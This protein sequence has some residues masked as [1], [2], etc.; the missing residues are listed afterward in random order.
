[1]LYHHRTLGDGAEGVHIREMVHALRALG[2]DVRVSGVAGE[3]QDS[4]AASRS[5]WAAAGN[6]LPGAMYEMAEIG[7]NAL[8]RAALS[9]A[10]R[11]F[12]PHVIYDRY[13]TY[14][15]AAVA[16]GRAYRIPVMLEVNAVAHER[17][18]YERHRLRMAP[19]ARAYERWICTA[20]DHVF[21]VSTPLARVLAAECGVDR[22]RLTVLPNG[23]NPATF[24]PELSGAPVRQR[25]GLGNR[26]VLGFVG[27]LRPW[28]G[29]DLLMDAL[30]ALRGRGHDVHALIVGDGPMQAVLRRHAAEARMLD[31]VTFTGRLPHAAVREHIA[32]MDVAVSPSATF[33]ASPMKILEYMAMGKPVVAPAMD[34]IR[35]LIDD[36]RTG[37]LFTPDDVRDLVARV[38][39]L[40]ASPERRAALGAAARLEVERSRNWETN[41]RIVVAAALPLG[42]SRH[43]RTSSAVAPTLG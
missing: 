42:G 4:P 24:T 17:I 14:S 26:L 6:L 38:D 35:D 2:H 25:L 12:R 37:V 23:A 11:R 7:S 18:A 21:A 1:V 27:I 39:D 34:N 32:A 43:P 33:Y 8:A 16:V 40:L 9:R 36:G 29:L 28:H 10:V 20:A 3:P 30:I 19:L 13:S 41:A 22:S 31:R 5:R 15:T